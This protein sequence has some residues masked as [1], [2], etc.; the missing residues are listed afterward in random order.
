MKR[1]KLLIVLVI[2]LILIIIGILIFINQEENKQSLIDD[3]TGDSGEEVSFNTTKLETVTDRTRFFTVKRCIQQYFDEL[4]ENNSKYFGRD[5]NGKDAK[6]MTDEEIN[7]IRYDLLSKKFIDKN[8]VT[9]ENVNDY[10]EIFNR[11]VIFNALQMKS[12]NGQQIE[13]YVVFGNI[14]S[15][16][17]EYIK[18]IFI[19]VNLDRSQQTFSI[20]PLESSKYTSIDDINIEYDDSQIPKND[21]NKYIIKEMSN[22]ET[23]KEYFLL[24]KRML[25]AKPDVIYDHLQEDY[26][27]KR[28]EN[29]DDFK[30]Y[31]EKNKEEISNLQIQ[32][33]MVKYNGNYTEFLC[34]DQYQNIYAFNEITPMNLEIKMDNYTIISDEFKEKYDQAT[35]EEKVV[36]NIDKWIQM[37]NSRD[38]KSAYEV[39]NETF[40][41]NNWGSEEEFESYMKEKFPIHYK[42]EYGNGSEN[43]GIYTQEIT[44]SDVTGEKYTKTSK[45][46]IMQ[47]KDNY[48]FEMSFN[49][50]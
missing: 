13:N 16:D 33:Y 23:A 30:S 36:L 45:D 28:F 39:L 1:L 42:V 21:N 20:E 17:N 31:I 5:E 12:I 48:E 44:L 29:I 41:N 11:K 15:L 6:I 46:I 10:L 37:I 2:V 50:E 40:R 34:M 49:V 25:Q 24:Y 38:Y 32:K 47:L 35:D 22:E 27:K 18:D 26:K 14:T 8:K 9:I 19:I 3:S 7:K 43:N 4:N